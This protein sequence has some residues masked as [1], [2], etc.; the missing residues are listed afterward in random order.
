M[1]LAA[2]PQ[3]H[4]RIDTEEHGDERDDHDA[5]TTAADTAGHAYPA[6]VLD[7]FAAPAVFPKH[8]TS[9]YHL[10]KRLLAMPLFTIALA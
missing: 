5:H 2:F 8:P 3:D 7:V 10:P 6:P 1:Y 4:A 9:I